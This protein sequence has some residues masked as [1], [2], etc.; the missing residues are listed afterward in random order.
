VLGQP[1]LRLAGR[2]VLGHPVGGDRTA[3]DDEQEDHECAHPAR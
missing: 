2:E 1:G 3:G